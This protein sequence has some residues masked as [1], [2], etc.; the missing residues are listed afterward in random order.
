[1]P[2]KGSTFTHKDV[3]TEVPMNDLTSTR[4][5]GQWYKGRVQPTHRYGERNAKER[6]LPE[7]GP[8]L[9]TGFKMI[10]CE[11]LDWDPCCIRGL[12]ISTIGHTYKHEPEFKALIKKYQ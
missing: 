1:M 11:G 12:V 4:I 7:G 8:S 10:S 2:R 9:H 3:G 6:K 5:C